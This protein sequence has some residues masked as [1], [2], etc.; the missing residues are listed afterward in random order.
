HNKVYVFTIGQS[1]E[2][3]KAKALCEKIDKLL[4]D[5]FALIGVVNETMAKDILAIP[6]STV[7]Y[8]A[9]SPVKAVGCGSKS[10]LLSEAMSAT[11]SGQGTNKGKRKN[12]A[13][14]FPH[15]KFV[16]F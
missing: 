11:S 15:N 5:L 8:E 12:Q 16:V 10:G 3:D 2:Q 1:Y 13:K 9:S 14:S 4:D 6:A 7:A